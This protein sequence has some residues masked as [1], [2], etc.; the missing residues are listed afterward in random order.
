MFN[1]NEHGRKL[2]ESTRLSELRAWL[3]PLGLKVDME[4]G[5]HA[6]D[7]RIDMVVRVSRASGAA[8]T[9]AVEI[10]RDVPPAM[11]TALHPHASLPTLVVARWITEQ[12]AG[13]MRERG[14]DYVD[15]AGNAHIAWGDVL[16]DVRGRRKTGSRGGGSLPRG[17]KAFSR[18]GLQVGFVLLS[19][20]SMAGAPLRALASASGV[21]LG[22]AQAAVEDLAK[23]GYLYEVAD[24]RQLGRAGELLNRWS[25]A[26]S[27]RLSPTLSL[28]D[29]AGSDI[30]WWRGSEDEL[31]RIDVQVGGE[32]GASVLDPHL[33]PATLTLYAEDRP[34]S[35]IGEHRLTLAGEV[36]NVH[37]R[38]R[39]WTMPRQ[40]WIVPP[41]L[42]YADLLAS[43][44]SRQRE[45]A[46]R[47]RISDDRL[48]GLD[49]I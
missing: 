43:G 16:V 27:T 42:I 35:L 18:A 29:F 45:H 10:K 22:T 11:A 28:G 39:F 25:E 48:A 5:G 32:A 33:I 4:P 31:T 24:K 13:L 14:I 46:D 44:D 41:T 36:G 49:R 37:M 34:R 23:A 12:A 21:S 1:E 17:T 2:N 26:Y 20:P 15:E 40:S 7:H 6:S 30:S 3:S 38:R 47:I 9:Y 8:R 19:W